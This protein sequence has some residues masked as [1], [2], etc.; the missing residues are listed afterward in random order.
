MYSTVFRRLC[1][2]LAGGDGG[3]RCGSEAEQTDLRAGRFAGAFAP[4][5]AAVR[6]KTSGFPVGEGEL[7]YGADSG[8]FRADG[9][10]TSVCG[11]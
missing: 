11:L 7:L 2:D 6:E 9:G 1:A 10:G 8:N 3:V 5:G 4:F